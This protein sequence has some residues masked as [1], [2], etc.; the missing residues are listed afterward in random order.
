MSASPGVSRLVF[1]GT[2]GGANAD[3]A[4]AA[5]ALQVSPGE[6]IL[7]DTS[8]GFEL[9]RNLKRAGIGLGSIRH[10]FISHRHSDHVSGLEPLLL[11]VALQA[12]ESETPAPQIH[13]HAHPLVIEACHELF[14]S[15]ASTAPALLGAYGGQVQWNH[16]TPDQPAQLR[17]GITLT[18]VTAEHMPFDG[19]ALSCLLEVQLPDRAW[20][21]AY[22]GDTRPNPEEE[23]MVQGADVL[24]HEVHVLDAAADKAHAIGH[25]AAGEVG[26]LAA[27]AGAGKLVLFHVPDESS[28][29][30]LRDEAARFFPRAVSA[31]NDL[32]VLDLVES[33][34]QVAARRILAAAGN[35]A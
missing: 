24:I 35:S 31:P 11:H 18:P 12:M 19:S 2:G 5:I 20:R 22:S 6:T 32:D 3:R 8:G 15:M 14:E 23:R 33:P 4:H 9:V 13:V 1:L 27:R 28:V 17:P 29:A 25:S 21:I 16:L 7:L 10:I 34:D 26:R 30:A